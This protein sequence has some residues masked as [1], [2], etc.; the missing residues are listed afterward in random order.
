MPNFFLEAPS[1]GQPQEGTVFLEQEEERQSS[2]ELS[3]AEERPQEAQE[4]A[5]E[6]VQEKPEEAPKKEQP[7]I[8]GKFKS[9]EDLLKSYEEAQRELTR[10]SQELAKLQAQYDALWKQITG[11]QEGSQQASQAPHDDN[12]FLQ[13]FLAS[14][15]KA[16]ESL[17][18]R[19][20]TPL[21]TTLEK[22]QIEQ[23]TNYW[24]QRE[25]YYEEVFGQQFS[26][27]KPRIYDYIRQNPHL[28][29][30]RDGYDEAVKYI[31]GEMALSGKVVPPKPPS[32]EPPKPAPSPQYSREVVE[33]ARRIGKKP[34][35][36]KEILERLKAG[37]PV[38]M[39]VE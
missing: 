39:E 6:E 8:G 18:Q 10:R 37:Q 35:E 3:E 19:Y 15:R 38:P 33:F 29:N 25:K 31:V 20:I 21:Q 5:Q 9:Y 27:L 14:P 13:Q 4:G 16:L 23:H 12:E 2:Q 17:L 1:E 34:E 32:I 7:L 22:F 26:A 24:V 28:V 11:T 36:A 30:K